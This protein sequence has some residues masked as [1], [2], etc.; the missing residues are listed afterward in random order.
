MS[1]PISSSTSRSWLYF[2]RFEAEVHE[3]AG[4]EGVRLIELVSFC[5]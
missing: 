1:F 4:D 2:E 3:G 5:I